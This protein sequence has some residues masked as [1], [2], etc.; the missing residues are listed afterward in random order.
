MYVNQIAP[1]PHWHAK[2]EAARFPNAEIVWCQEEPM[3]MGAWSYVCPRLET[4]LR[5]DR[6]ENF[7]PK[8]VWKT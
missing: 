8:Y 1:F 5:A 3:N 6:G 4:A 2:N 7:R